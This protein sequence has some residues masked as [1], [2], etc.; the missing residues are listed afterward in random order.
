LFSPSADGGILSSLRELT[1]LNYNEFDFFL[2]DLSWN[3]LLPMSDNFCDSFNLFQIVN[4]YTRPNQKYSIIY[5]ILTNAP[6][7][8]SSTVV[9][10]FFFK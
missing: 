5:L 8:Y 2:G 1:N 3:W 4:S 9:P 6:H 7:K 10:L